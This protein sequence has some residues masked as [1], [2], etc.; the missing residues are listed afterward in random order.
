MRLKSAKRS[1]PK[2]EIPLLVEYKGHLW[3]GRRYYPRYYHPLDKKY[4]GRYK[5]YNNYGESRTV[6]KHD[7]IKYKYV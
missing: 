7:N 6:W 1:E 2:C 3:L 4:K 5:L